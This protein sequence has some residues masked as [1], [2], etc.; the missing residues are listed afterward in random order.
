MSTAIKEPKPKQASPRDYEG[1]WNADGSPHA[2]APNG[3]NIA[4]R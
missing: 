4:P 3:Q 1:H 2:H